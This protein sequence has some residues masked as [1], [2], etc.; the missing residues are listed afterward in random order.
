MKREN[1]ESIYNQSY[2]FLSQ[3]NRCM[4]C[5]VPSECIDHVPPINWVESLGSK[6]FK[7][8]GIQLYFVNSCVD[9]NSK[10]SDLALFTI[11]DRKI[12]L[13]GRYS[14]KHRKILLA[15]DWSEE[16]LKSLSRNL[17]QKIRHKMKKKKFLLE[18]LNFLRE[19]V[20]G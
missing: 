6:Y 20:E 3:E 19:P 17:A 9:C 13:F 12:Y 5:G 7:E 11:L 4:Y 18:R 10:L 1:K 2:S 14:K 15:P 8:K 16:E